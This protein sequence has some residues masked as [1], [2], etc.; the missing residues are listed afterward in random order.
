MRKSPQDIRPERRAL[1][2]FA[3]DPMVAR[4]GDHRVTIDVP[5]SKM[6]WRPKGFRDDRIEVIDYDGANNTYYTAIQLDDAQIAMQDGV[7][8]AEADPQFHQQMVY[9][10]A[11]RVL[12]NFDRALGRRVRFWGNERLRL[13]PHA[14][15]GRNAFFDPG[16]NSVLFGYFRADEDDAGANLP[17][18]LVFTC[19]SHDIVAHEVTHAVLDRLHRHFREPTNPHVPALHEAF[20][21]IVAM[22][23]RF[24]FPEVV[25]RVM[26]D[27]RGDLLRRSPLLEIGAQFGAAVGLGEALRTVGQAPDPTL[28]ARTR[29]PHRLGRV[30]VAAVYEGFVRAFERRT[31][32]LIAIATGGSG[33][34]PE[35]DLHPDLVARL[36]SEGAKTAQLVLTMVIRATDYLPPVD[37]TF[38]DFLRAMV[39]AD[40]ELH[41]ADEIR[42]R[43]S[44][45]EAFR[46]HGI[47]PEAVGSLSVE[48]LLLDPR[49]PADSPNELLAKCVGE[50][51]HLGMRDMKRSTMAEKEEKRFL[52]PAPPKVESSADF[53]KQQHVELVREEDDK[54]GDIDE[55]DEDWADIGKQ[56]GLWAKTEGTRAKLGLDEKRPVQITGFH[57]VH[58]IAA[59][60]ELL[61][62]MVA[63][64]VQA[65]APDDELGG[66]AFSAGAT[67][68]AG[69][70][71]RLRYVISKPFSK[72]RRARVSEWV[73]AFERDRNPGF[74]EL[75][76]GDTLR[77]AFSS[78]AM[79]GRRWR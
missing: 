57:P 30:L 70:D 78:R 36:A 26:S 4:A 73:R 54:Q 5:Y 79:D 62:E 13:F 56:L 11:A 52:R 41:R 37:P 43:A 71:G 50:L 2:I 58:R 16:T 14:F 63:H 20:A 55:P 25:R 17:G 29:E 66:L 19:L 39:T 6:Q 38:S 47:R 64:L 74:R 59:G 31:K 27:T 8:P 34:L 1:K 77:E 33:R 61:V 75:R 46:I 68:V 53:I 10:V 3:F 51:L 18:Q 76:P 15:E 72:E 32:D 12:E 69:I 67:I 48:S 9:A 40:Y 49:D 22:L 60:G 7:E 45:I 28:I 65:G 24:T 23:Q 44:M 35:G 21:D 42:L